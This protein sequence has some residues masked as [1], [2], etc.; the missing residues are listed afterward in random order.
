MKTILWFTG[1]SG[2]GKTTIARGLQKKLEGLG[3]ATYILDGDMVR[4]TLN[5]SLGFERKDIRE[6]NHLIAKLA[7]EKSK[8]YD[9]VLVSII[10]PYKEDRMMAREIVGKNFLEVLVDCP[11]SICEERDVKGLY[12]K[13][14]AGKIKNFIGLSKLSPYERPYK[15]DIVVH[16]D[17][18]DEKKSVTVILDELVLRGH[19]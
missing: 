4:M 15:P 13:A 14:R 18:M 3:K 9:I 16:T 2:S 7:K 8:K 19:I 5:K 12:K 17:R 1:L 11:L 6:N 10:S